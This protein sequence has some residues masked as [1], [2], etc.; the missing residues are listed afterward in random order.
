MHLLA[1]VGFCWYCCVT[2]ARLNK[3]EHAYQF[4]LYFCAYF[5]PRDFTGPE[6]EAER[7]QSSE[8]DITRA[9]DAPRLLCLRRLSA[10]A[11]FVL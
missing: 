11:I 1:F 9:A 8:E 7:D 10:G 5:M 2:A 3:L 4:R 6:H